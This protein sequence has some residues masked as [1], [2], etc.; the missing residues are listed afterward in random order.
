MD[1]TFYKELPDLI[2]GFTKSLRVENSYKFKP[3]KKGITKNGERLSLGFSCYALKIYYMTGELSNFK[4]NEL[5]GWAKY[6]NSF[7]THN[8]NYLTDYFIDPIFEKYYTSVF[9]KE[10]VTSL[11]KNILNNF[12]N[13]NYDSK[14]IKL[15]KGLAAETKQA[16]ATLAEIGK[17]NSNKIEFE[18][19]SFKEI[20]LY[21]DS[22][23]WSK[24]WSAGG[25]FS[26]FC[27]YSTTQNLKY[28]Q[29]L[30][31]YVEKLAD[32]V[33]GSYFKE[34]PNSSREF[35]NGGMKI[36]SGL[37][38]LD[39]EIHYPSKLIDY[40]LDNKPILEGCDIVDFVY[41]LFKCSQQSNHRK[42][43]IS[44]LFAELLDDIQKLFIKDLG[45]Y[46]YFQNKSQ[47]HYYGVPISRGLNTPDLHGSLLCLWAVLMILKFLE[48]ANP[49]WN[50][51]K[52]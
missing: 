17:S 35:I 39:E 50:I 46:S 6:I 32:P 19:K 36:I 38:W 41:V 15:Q 27:I 8:D 24:P 49:N 34:T 25:Q 2:L 11:T 44:K 40:C 22:L 23:D 51:I 29:N 42:I 1:R 20:E 10:T 9:S 48:I 14:K 33:S 12:T 5:D 18:H 16:L 3:L 26:S 45:G 47:T 21:L 7:Q 43:E 37:D 31:N 52:P 13:K 28:E 30:L 4:E